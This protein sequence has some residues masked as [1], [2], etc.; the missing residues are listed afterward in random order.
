MGALSMAGTA[1]LPPKPLRGGPHHETSLSAFDGAAGRGRD[2]DQRPFAE[3]FEQEESRGC[4][5]HGV[6]SAVHR[7][8]VRA[9]LRASLIAQARH[10]AHHAPSI[11]GNP[12]SYRRARW[13][14]AHATTTQQNMKRTG[15][16][17]EQIRR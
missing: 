6:Q 5:R 7:A 11:A 2:A 9:W 4:G 10:T 1:M 13:P 16:T 17:V 3:G 15:T 14:V 8:A 12:H